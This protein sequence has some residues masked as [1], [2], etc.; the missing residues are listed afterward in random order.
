MLKE[1]RD[2]D[3]IIDVGAGPIEIAPAPFRKNYIEEYFLAKN[4]KIAALGLEGLDYE[5]FRQRYS[6]CALIL[7]DGIHFPKDEV[8]D[9]ALCSA[10]IEHIGTGAYGLEKS[11]GGRQV[12]YEWLCGL[13]KICKK[14]IITSPNRF[15]VY[16]LHSQLFLIHWF[17]ENAR[18]CLYRL[19]RIKKETIDVAE[20]L[21]LLSRKELIA[22]LTEA[23][24]TIKKVKRN[25][26]CFFTIDFLVVAVNE[27]LSTA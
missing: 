24:F 4:R 15:A 23:G 9:V 22:L 18:K 12:Q 21:N 17:G 13:A 25:R 16:E 7:F 2:K 20:D 19:F 5:F 26:L 10:V 3:T 27:N 11:G 1:I 14:L 8:Y 6:N